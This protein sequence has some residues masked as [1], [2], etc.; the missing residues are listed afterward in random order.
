[1]KV[2]LKSVLIWKQKKPYVIRDKSILLTDFLGENSIFKGIL[3]VKKLCYDEVTK[4][5]ATL[6]KYES[7]VQKCKKKSYKMM[8]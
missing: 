3:I 8:R 7:E 2:G 5:V 4:E 6:C 1:M